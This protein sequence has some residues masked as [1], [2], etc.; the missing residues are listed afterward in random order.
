MLQVWTKFINSPRTVDVGFALISGNLM[1]T[2]DM[3]ST[4]KMVMDRKI[5]N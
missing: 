1:M 2:T 5:I 3:P 4:G